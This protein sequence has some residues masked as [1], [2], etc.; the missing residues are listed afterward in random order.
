MNAL[1]SI[2]KKKILANLVLNEFVFVFVFVFVGKLLHLNVFRN[3][4][5]EYL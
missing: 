4:F 2:K 3:N 5:F 1:T